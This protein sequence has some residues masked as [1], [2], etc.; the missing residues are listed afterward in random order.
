[1]SYYNRLLTAIIAL[2]CPLF[3]YGQVAVVPTGGDGDMVSYT[4]GQTV[5]G[6]DAD[7][8]IM[9]PVGSREQ[10]YE[11]SSLNRIVRV[12]VVKYSNE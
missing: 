12:T 6:V 5:A 1:M 11:R 4:I 2:L 9:N 10:V 8:I 3:F 7:K